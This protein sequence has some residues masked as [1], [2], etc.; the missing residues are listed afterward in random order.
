MRAADHTLTPRTDLEVA[1]PVVG[2]QLGWRSWSVIVASSLIGLFTIAWP[3]LMPAVDVSPQHASDAP[4]VF[5]FLLP[6]VLMLVVAQISDGGLDSK[7]LA[8]LGVLSAINAAIRPVLGAGTAGVESIF[9]LLILAGRVFGPGF[10]YLLGFTSMFAS[11]LLTAGVGPWLPSQMLCAA[12]V[13]LGAGLL[14]RRVGGR[15]ELWLLVAYGIVAAYLYGAMMNLWFW[16]FISGIQVGADP[17]GLG[18]LDYVPGAPPGENLVR[19]A[20]F[21]LISSTAG[22]DTGRAI[23][24]TIALLLLG[25]PVMG[26]LRRAS[27]MARIVADPSGTA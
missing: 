12:W 20:W 25:R 3:L 1:A 2:V 7:A 9:F 16:P 24:T 18:S 11:A 10:G 8:L 5:A 19:F 26:V 15:T 27:G 13:G 21:T 23:T 17:G 6:V 14:P 4:F 22:W